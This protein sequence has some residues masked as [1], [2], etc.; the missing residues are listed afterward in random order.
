MKEIEEAD[1]H[2]DV[3]LDAIPSLP[4]F[5]YWLYLHRE[6]SAKPYSI[7]GSPAKEMIEDLKKLDIFENYDKSIPDSLFDILCDNCKDAIR[8]ANRALR[9]AR[10]NDPE[11]E[12]FH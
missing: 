6:Y 12:K 4:C 7:H 5:E 9:Q 2:S 1:R 8:H 3:T 10:D 11:V